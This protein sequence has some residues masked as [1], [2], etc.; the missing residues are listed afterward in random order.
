MQC[1]DDV[2][3]VAFELLKPAVNKVLSPLGVS[4]QNAERGSD[5]NPINGSITKNILIGLI[6]LFCIIV[7]IAGVLTIRRKRIP[8]RDRNLVNA[9]IWV[10]PKHDLT[11]KFKYCIIIIRF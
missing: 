10:P 5:D 7:V 11:S 8:Y 2:T 4:L 6:A 9:S 3:Q 1:P